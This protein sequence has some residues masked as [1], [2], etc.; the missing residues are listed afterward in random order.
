[1]FKMR[2]PKNYTK[3][4]NDCMAFATA[5]ACNTSYDNV[6]ATMRREGLRSSGEIRSGKM[7]QTLVNETM[8]QYG[9]K[10]STR[11]LTPNP[12]GSKVYDVCEKYNEGTYL[13][14]MSIGKTRTHIAFMKNG[15][16]LDSTDNSNRVVL[17]LYKVTDMRN[18]TD[19]TPDEAEEITNVITPELEI[20]VVEQVSD[21]LPAEKETEEVSQPVDSQEDYSIYESQHI[22]TVVDYRDEE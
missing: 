14:H 18:V 1:M 9:R 19:V 16:L 17:K 22:E 4:S 5:L 13:V 12:E 7:W 21:A 2:F 15:V 11:G 20:E 6:Y 8:K 10:L 3:H